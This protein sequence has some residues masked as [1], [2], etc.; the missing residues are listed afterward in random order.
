MPAVAGP[1]LAAVAAGYFVVALLHLSQSLRGPRWREAYAT[2]NRRGFA[3]LPGLL[4]NTDVRRP[5]HGP[6]VPAER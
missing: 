1:V 3:S 5:R 6:P 2:A 4:P